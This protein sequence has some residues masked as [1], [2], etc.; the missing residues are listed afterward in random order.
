MAHDSSRLTSITD[1]QDD[2]LEWDGAS[3]RLECLHENC[4]YTIHLL[5]NVTRRQTSFCYNE[6]LCVNDGLNDIHRVIYPYTLRIIFQSR[7][8]DAYDFEAQLNG[9]TLLCK[10]L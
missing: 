3:F 5:R 6:L 9:T 10:Y 4:W 1:L 8:I 7:R 2:H